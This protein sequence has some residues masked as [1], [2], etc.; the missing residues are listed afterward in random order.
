MSRRTEVRLIYEGKNISQDIAPY[1]LS[2]RYTDNGAGKSDDLSIELHDRDGKWHGSWMPKMGDRINASIVLLDWTKPESKQILKCGTFEVDTVQFSGPP[3]TV[4]IGAVAF[5]IASGLKN[6]KKTKAWEKVTLKQIA[7]RIADAAGLRLQYETYNVTYDRVDQTQQT[8]IAFLAQLAEREGATV[9]ITNG[10]LVVYD[11]RRLEN[12]PPSRTIER[13]K[14]DVKSY[15]FDYS[16]VGA[17]YASCTITYYDSRKKRTIKGTYRIPGAKGPALKI[18]ERVK[19]EAEAIRVA[20]NA[21]R[22]ENRDAQRARFRLVGDPGIVQ[23]ITVALKG[24]G[25][26][27]G[28]YF[29]EA[30]TH[31]VGGGGFETDIQLR[32]VLTY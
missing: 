24:Y 21:L 12:V 18:N 31:T 2:L 16:V 26:F 4:T 11:D 15:S 6:E 22:Q 20:R 10:T 17:A 32:K 7:R 3:D 8:D 19:S 5:P 14:S 23:G 13:G 1:L 25:K 29:V 28:I 27:D 30:A 9:K